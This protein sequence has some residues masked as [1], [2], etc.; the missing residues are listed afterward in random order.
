MLIEQEEKESREGKTL[1]QTCPYIIS[2]QLNSLYSTGN[3]L[4]MKYYNE[5]KLSVSIA[6]GIA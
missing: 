3:K 2:P 4:E 6:M 5:E 1:S